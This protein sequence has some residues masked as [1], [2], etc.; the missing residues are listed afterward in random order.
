MW[1]NNAFRQG[2]SFTGDKAPPTMVLFIVAPWC[3]QDFAYD[4]NSEP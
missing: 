1:Q 2:V 3:H 4:H